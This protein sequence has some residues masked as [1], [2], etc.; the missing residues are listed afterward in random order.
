MT[1][2]ELNEV[3]N[4]TDNV[5]NS[6]ASEGIKQHC[7]PF[8][9]VYNT[10]VFVLLLKISHLSIVFLGQVSEMS[11]R[12][13][14]ILDVDKLEHFQKREVQKLCSMIDRCESMRATVGAMHDEEAILQEQMKHDFVQLISILSGQDTEQ[15][16]M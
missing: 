6:G 8:S 4:G 2:V 12:L 7:E 9:L 11:H 13:F 15:Q 1:F 16:H 3:W 10:S 5:T 14:Q